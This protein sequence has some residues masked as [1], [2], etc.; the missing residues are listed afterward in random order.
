M[1]K[2]EAIKTIKK[3]KK[4]MQI[5]GADKELDSFENGMEYALSLLEG[6]TPNYRK[7]VKSE[8]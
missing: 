4:N 8:S 5:E 3:A 7:R 6:R 1:N 2:E